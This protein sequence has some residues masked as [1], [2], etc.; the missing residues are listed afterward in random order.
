MTPRAPRLPRRLPEAAAAASDRLVEFHGLWT[1]DPGMQRVFRI[2]EKAAQ[3]EARVLLRGETGTGKELLARALHELSP[4]HSGPFHAISCAALP[5]SLRRHAP[6]Q[7][8][9]SRR[10]LA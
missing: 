8:R 7:T 3:S 10:W 5:A 2:V 9:G 1:C 6:R 4:R